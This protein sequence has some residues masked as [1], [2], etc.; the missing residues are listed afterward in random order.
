[1]ILSRQ[2]PSIIAARLP[3]A[4]ATFLGEEGLQISELDVVIAHPGGP[5][6]LDAVAESLNL[7]P[8]KLAQSRRV[9]LEYGNG[10]SAGIFF[11]LEALAE[12]GERGEALA[13]AFGPGLSIELARMRHSA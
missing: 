1:V 7:S 13:V 10:S 6:I 2:L 12:P 8:G 5:R 11:V 3:A 9:F 4:V